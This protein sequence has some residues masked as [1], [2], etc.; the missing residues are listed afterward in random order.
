[1]AADLPPQAPRAAPSQSTAHL[2]S[3]QLAFL[4]SYD[5]HSPISVAVQHTGVYPTSIHLESIQHRP[6]AGVTGIYRV[7]TARPVISSLEPSE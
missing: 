6:G 2:E 5:A 7:A 1:M 3:R 4:E